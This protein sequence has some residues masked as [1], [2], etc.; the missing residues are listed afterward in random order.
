VNG[1]I[2]VDEYL[3]ASFLSHCGSQFW[4]MRTSIVSKCWRPFLNLQLWWWYWV[5]FNTY[6]NEIKV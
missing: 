4:K 1:V 6:Y 2:V 3:F 5:D